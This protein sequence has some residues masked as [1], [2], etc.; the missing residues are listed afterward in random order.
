MGVVISESLNINRERERDERAR[1]HT[2]TIFYI[3]G[4]LYAQPNGGKLLNQGV[5]GVEQ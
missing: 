3:S 4:I 2:N 5:I 1:E